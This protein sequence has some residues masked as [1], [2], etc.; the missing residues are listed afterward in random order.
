[1]PVVRL[2]VEEIADDAVGDQLLDGHEL[3]VPAQYEA[4]DGLDPRPRD[5]VANGERV[6]ERH[7]DRLL[8]DDVPTGLRSPHAVLSP[9]V[10]VRA[11]DDDLD[12]LVVVELVEGRVLA[13]LGP[14]GREQS[15]G[16]PRRAVVDA[17][18]L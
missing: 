11:R 6:L 1:M 18:E 7:S 2:P 9:R 16:L 5:R 14:E 10:R 12:P 15:G 3:R 4:G 8:D 17:D 13:R